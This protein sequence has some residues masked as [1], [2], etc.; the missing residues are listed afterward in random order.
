MKKIILLLFL[1][2]ETVAASPREQ[3]AITKAN[4]NDSGFAVCELFTSEGCSSCPP[5][6]ALLKKL[7][8]EYAGTNVYLLEFHV[9]YWDKL[10][11]KD[12]YS[13]P[14]FSK[15]QYAYNTALKVQAYT[16]QMVIN[17]KQEMIGSEADKVHTA[18]NQ[19]TKKY[20]KSTNI[21]YTLTTKNG[22]AELTYTASTFDKK[23]VIN[24]ALVQKEDI[25]EIKAGENKGR[26]IQHIAIVRQFVTAPISNP[27]GK[28]SI[29]IPAE[30]KNKAL[31]LIVYT[32]NSKN[33]NI[34]SATALNVGENL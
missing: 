7:E 5:A 17:G 8:Q 25:N 11:W 10:G 2:C 14:A 12:K 15:R 28:L 33:L 6:E 34:T 29:E 26:T 18:I 1:L 30:L 13:S 9:D 3:K 19:V 27:S 32:Q 24:A 4:S 21:E 22:Q 23:D 16:P 31:K 20:K